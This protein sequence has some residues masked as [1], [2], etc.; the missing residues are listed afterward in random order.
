MWQGDTIV[1]IKCTVLQKNKGR[2]A[3]NKALKGAQPAGIYTD[4][5]KPQ[6]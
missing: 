3:D 1:A 2:Q 6:S 5:P 4:S